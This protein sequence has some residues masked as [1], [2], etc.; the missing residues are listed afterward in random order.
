MLAHLFAATAILSAN[1]LCRAS[2]VFLLVCAG[3]WRSMTW[4]RSVSLSICFK[5]STFLHGVPS[6][7]RHLQGARNEYAA[8][9][10]LLLFLRVITH[11]PTCAS[12]LGPSSNTLEV[13]RGVQARLQPTTHPGMFNTVP[14]RLCTTYNTCKI[15]YVTVFLPYFTVSYPQAAGSAGNPPVTGL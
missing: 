15:R 14:Q 9:A 7:L 10:R 6:A 2:H 13:G 12:L 1:A 8:C 11:D 3:V 5:R 4:R